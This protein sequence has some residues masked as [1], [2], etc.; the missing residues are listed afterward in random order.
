MKRM[1]SP[2]QTV[3]RAIANANP[4]RAPSARRSRSICLDWAKHR[5]RQSLKKKIR[6]FASLALVAA[7][8]GALELSAQ[9][10]GGAGRGA[11]AA[12]TPA[13]ASGKSGSKSLRPAD[14]RRVRT[15]VQA[16]LGWRVEIPGSVF[17]QLS[18]WRA[19]GMADALGLGYIEGYSSEKV[20]PQI[21]RNLTIISRRPI[22]R[23]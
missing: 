2:V 11:G 21:G 18:F 23:G 8:V 13:S 12:A 10:P 19:A 17:R 4:A 20:S 15:E 14:S 6:G 5:R 22:S 16:L 1:A 7:T 9:A 3:D